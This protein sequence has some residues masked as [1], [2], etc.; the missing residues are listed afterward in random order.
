MTQVRTKPS[1]REI[2][3]HALMSAADDPTAT[4]VSSGSGEGVMVL[5]VPP[6]LL[7]MGSSEVEPGKAARSSR[8]LR[9]AVFAASRGSGVC[10][11]KGSRGGV[12]RSGPAWRPPMNISDVS[13]GA[14]ERRRA[15]A[16]AG[17]W[18]GSGFGTTVW[19]TAAA[20]AV[21]S[22]PAW[23]PPTNIS[24]VEPGSAGRIC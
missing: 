8:V 19:A 4:V 22:R 14:A 10:G 11:S 3:V 18:R 16:L 2:R 12:V 5:S 7:M 24:E 9:A 17:S 6:C 1:T 21:R 23:R 15:F 13:P 20:I